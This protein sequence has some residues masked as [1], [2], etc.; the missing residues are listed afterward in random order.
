MATTTLVCKQCNFENEPERVYCHNCGAKLDRSLLP[1]EATKRE[2]PVLVQE[3][4]RRMVKPRNAT[5]NFHLKNLLSSVVLAGLFAVLVVIIKPPEVKPMLSPDQ[6]MDAPAIVDD[7]DGELQQPTAHRLAYTE[8]QINAFLQ[9]S[10]R[11]NKGDKAGTPAMKFERAFVRLEDGVCHATMQESLFGLPIYATT[12]RSLSVRNGAITTQ[13]LGASLGRLPIPARLVPAF[14][15]VFRPLKTVLEHP[16]KLLSQ[17][18]SVTIRKG[19]VE[20]ITTP[21]RR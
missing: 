10:L 20:M 18:Q 8:D 5:L 13:P 16:L 17:M 21:A 6:V 19:G 11:G 4:V 9:Q 7:M 14:E 3:R 1:P 15:F 12:V 2:D